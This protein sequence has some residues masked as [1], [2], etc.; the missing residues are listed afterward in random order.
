MNINQRIKMLRKTL[1]LTQSDFGDGIGLKKGAISWMEQL[2]N[3]V[4][5]QNIKLICEKFNVNEEWLRNGTGEMLQ[6]SKQSDI[7]ALLQVELKLSDAELEVIKVF[8]ELTPVQRKM[9]IRFV[10]DISAILKNAGG[11]LTDMAQ[12]EKSFS[13]IQKNFEVQRNDKDVIEREVEAYRK[14]LEAE[15]S[16][17]GKLSALTNSDAEKNGKIRA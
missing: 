14:E 2:G 1:K 10:H 16:S 7:L 5:E 6:P 9:A 13:N 8:V 4:T 11:I 15:Y 3:T 12:I 17:N